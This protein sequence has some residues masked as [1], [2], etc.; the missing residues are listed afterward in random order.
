MIQA[1]PKN[2]DSKSPTSNDDGKALQPLDLLA[3]KKASKKIACLTAYDFRTA[4]LLDESSLDVILVGD[5]LANVFLGLENTYEIG[6]D[7]MVYHTKAVARAVKRALVIADL[8]FLSYQVSLE[9]A[10]LSAAELMK[11]GAKAVKLE[12]A[13]EHTLQVVEKLTEIGIPVVGHL[14][15]TPQSVNIIG[16]GRVQA[17]SEAEGRDLFNEARALEAAGALA[18]VLEL[19]PSELAAQITK[20]LKIPSIGIG[21]GSSCDGQILVVDDV[22]GRSDQELKIAK[23]YVDLAAETKKATQLFIKEV[24]E[25]VFPGKINSF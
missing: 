23:K 15:Y 5:S 21:A 2:V 25:G 8:P 12:G 10:I 6:L 16:R 18:V 7:E 11:A 9:E 13:S 3:F 24:K 20:T 19:I 4:Q 17:R 1:V 22:L 14:G